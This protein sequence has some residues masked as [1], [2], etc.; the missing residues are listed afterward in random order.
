MSPRTIRMALADTME[1][2]T[3]ENFDR[4]RHRL[5]DYKGK[6]QSVRRVQVEGKTRL[7]V[8][9]VLVST[10]TEPGAVRVAVKLLRQIHH[11][12]LW[13][14]VG[15]MTRGSLVSYWTNYPTSIYFQTASAES[16]VDDD[17]IC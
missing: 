9:D 4:F 10:F 12:D 8:V 1:D 2:L 13:R 14:T 16:N 5:L 17:S 11:S 15:A 6:A 7:Q 3:A